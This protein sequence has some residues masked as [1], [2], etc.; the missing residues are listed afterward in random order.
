VHLKVT[1]MDQRKGKVS[2]NLS[3]SETMRLEKLIGKKKPITRM[4][5]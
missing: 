4:G 5:C 2:V 1:L 3:R